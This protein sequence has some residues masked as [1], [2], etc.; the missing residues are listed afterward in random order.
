MIVP[1]RCVRPLVRRPIH[2]FARTRTTLDHETPPRTHW[3]MASGSAGCA[4]RRAVRAGESKPV[5]GRDTERS[6]VARCEALQST[7]PQRGRA[8]IRTRPPVSPDLR[9]SVTT[10]GNGATGRPTSLRCDPGPSSPGK[11]PKG[12]RTPRIVLPTTA[13]VMSG[14]RPGPT[15]RSWR[16]PD[17]THASTAT[18]PSP[19]VGPGIDGARR[20]RW[21]CRLGDRPHDQ[22]LL[23]RL[24]HQHQHQGGGWSTRSVHGASAWSWPT[25]KA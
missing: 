4:Q 9:D 25:A 19:A 24:A 20:Y 7:H 13:C 15:L 6:D 14:A 5:E 16:D 2:A 12:I 17:P 10:S 3:A 11:I 18:M 1:L 22:C 8:L 21:R 23:R